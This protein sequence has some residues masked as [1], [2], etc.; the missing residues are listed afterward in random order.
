[1]LLF[2]TQ[3]IIFVIC[4]DINNYWR[5]LF[6]YYLILVN[7]VCSDDARISFWYRSFKLVQP[8]SA[9]MGAHFWVAWK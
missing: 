1:M 7:K 4:E 2:F 8:M 6:L 5:I 9:T 3:D